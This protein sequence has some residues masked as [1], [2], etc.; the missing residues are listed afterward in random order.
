MARPRKFDEHEVVEVAMSLFAQ[1][2]FN[3][4]SIDD[5]VEATGL[6]RGSLYKAFGSK[7]NIFLLGFE[8]CANSFDV[9]DGQQLDLLTVALRDLAA[10]N[11]A[12]REIC[13]KILS[14]HSG[15]LALNLGNNLL[16]RME[17]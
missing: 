3:A 13:L 6:L 11:E 14:T 15:S 7:L 5:L 1:K 16:H 10:T 17:K 9:E 8:K 2:G 12:T 4:T